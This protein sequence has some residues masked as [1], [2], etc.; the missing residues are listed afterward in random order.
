MTGAE[1]YRKAEELLAAA[2]NAP[3]NGDIARAQAHAT[4]ANAAVMADAL[5]LDEDTD[6]TDRHTTIAA[7]RTAMGGG[8]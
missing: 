4:L 1:H 5:I 2:T 8:R 6:G 3:R 7:W